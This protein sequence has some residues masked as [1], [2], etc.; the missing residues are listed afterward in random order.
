ML[1]PV[2]EVISYSYLASCLRKKLGGTPRGRG[3]PESETTVPK[4]VLL[5]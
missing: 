1:T 2:P 4:A 3:M 5:Q